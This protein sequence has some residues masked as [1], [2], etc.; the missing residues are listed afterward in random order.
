MD[1]RHDDVRS[2]HSG[3]EKNG[4][5]HQYFVMGHLAVV[6][7]CQREA[8]AWNNHRLDC[9]TLKICCGLILEQ[10][11]P[12]LVSCCHCQKSRLNVEVRVEARVGCYRDQKAIK[13]KEKIKYIDYRTKV[14]K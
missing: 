9:S 10:V 11:L 13:I 5:G 1:Q 4:Q 2:L 12:S 14:A 3:L 8:A 6:D 7:Q